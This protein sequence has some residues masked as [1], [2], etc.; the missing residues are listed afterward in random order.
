MNVHVKRLLM[1][2]LRVGLGIGLAAW[3]LH[4]V[5]KDSGLTVPILETQLAGA[6]W[7]LLLLALAIYGAVQALGV[8]RWYLLLRVQGIRLPLF[9]LVRLHMIGVFFSS[10]IPGAVS[11]DLVKMVYVARHATGKVAETTLTIMLDRV[12]G[13]LGLFIVA[14]VATL[15]NLSYLHEAAAVSPKLILV[16]RLIAVLAAGSI[17]GVLAV[18]FHQLLERLPYV[19][20]LIVW[21]QRHLPAKITATVARLVAAL[22]L[23]R[24]HLGTVAIALLMSAMVHMLLAVLL[25]C[26][27]RGIHEDKVSLR[28]YMV[29][30]QYSNCIGSVPIV[31][32]GMGIRDAVT[33]AFLTV[34]NADLEKAGMVPLIN[35]C[36]GMFW[37][38]VGGVFFMFSR[39]QKEPESDPAL[40]G[41]AAEVEAEEAAAEASE[42]RSKAPPKG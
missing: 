15:A 4:K 23:Y 7:P 24:R 6:V 14:V 18:A 12:F 20:A 16:V 27:A 33:K 2:V 21:G 9:T 42:A 29:S 36:V 38:L 32:G 26:I 22:D 40:V 41:D 5:A 31:P 34:A 13:L 17:A 30:T 19:P 37:C 25:F 28:I 35:S 1:T 10:L 8:T 39:L 3:L 11:G